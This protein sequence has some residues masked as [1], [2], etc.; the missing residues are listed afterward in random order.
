MWRQRVDEAF[1]PRRAGARADRRLPLRFAA[2]RAIEALVDRGA[3]LRAVARRR[4]RRHVDVT[5]VRN[6]SAPIKQR[7]RSAVLTKKSS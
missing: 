1:A 3:S 5:L 7:D 6:R 2:F 4:A